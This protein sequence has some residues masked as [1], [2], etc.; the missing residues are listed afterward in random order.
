MNSLLLLTAIL[1]S[2]NDPWWAQ[3]K[4]KHFATAYIITKTSLHFGLDKNKS[5]GIALSISL[6]KEIYD[7]KVKKTIFSLKDLVYDLGGIALALLL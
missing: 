6:G 4:A 3:D 1:F 2:C 5:G 7:K